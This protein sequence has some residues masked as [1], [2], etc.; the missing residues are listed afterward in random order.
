MNY[1]NEFDANAAQ[2]LRELIADGLIPAGHVDERS[3]ADVNPEDLKGYTQCH[4]FA[5]IGGWS[6]ALRLAGWPAD[7]PVWTGSCP[8]QPFSLGGKRQGT[9]DHRDLWPVFS[10]LIR[11]SKPDVV[12]GEQVKDAIRWGW[13]DR[14]CDDLEAENYA[15]GSGVLSGA[16][17]GALHRRDRLYWVAISPN[18]NCEGR[19]GKWQAAKEPWSRQQFERLVHAELQVSVPAG[20]I[21]GLADG[22]PGRMDI[23]RG[24][25]NAIVPQVA[26]TFIQA[27]C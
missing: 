12:F 13:L 10:R 24:Y 25:G 9:N 20:S 15:C 14:L 18:T 17:I 22:L 27:C 23:L 8:C 4:F 7:R 2:W 21:G 16:S 11:Q 1:Y 26:A 19:E 6:Y 3:I 5:G